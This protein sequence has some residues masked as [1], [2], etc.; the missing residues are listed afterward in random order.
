MILCCGEALIDMLPKPLADGGEGFQPVVGGA[1]FNTAIA[2]GRLGARVGFFGGVS[3]DL[4]G[5]KILAALQQSQV[6]TEYT[7][8]LS[9]SSTLAFVHFVD[10]QAE[11]SFIDENSAMRGLR[12]DMLP[13]LSHDVTA[14]HF[15]GISLISEPCG[16]AYEALMRREADRR[17]ISFDPNIR[18]GF[19]AEHDVHRSRVQRMLALSD[20]V[21]VSDEDLAW[22]AP[23]IP[24]EQAIRDILAAGVSVVVLTK[25][26][27]GAVAWTE[28]FEV[29]AE[30]ES[31][32]VVD[33]IGAGDSF[34]AGF[35]SFLE[36][37]DCLDK[38]LRW[39]SAETLYEA[40]T[41]AH[42]VAAMTVSRTGA[43]SPWK[44]EV[45]ARTL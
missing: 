11:Y 20:L 7:M 13:E 45:I 4:F 38:N 41:F 30:V 8:Q 5:Q 3:T 6:D 2:L 42:A 1:V 17:M 10:A 44:D 32:K 40:M 39:L 28:D 16:T 26:A 15:G 29:H 18:T 25:G 33:T 27:H 35:L 22:I 12:S 34:N 37:W 23:G 9:Q 36:R 21:K 19:I 14:L 31:V 43:N 24:Q